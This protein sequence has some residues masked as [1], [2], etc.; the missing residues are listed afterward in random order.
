MSS[1]GA[2][3]KAVLKPGKCDRKVVIGPT[4]HVV[5]PSWRPKAE[6]GVELT[7]VLMHS[8]K[9]GQPVDTTTTF[10]DNTESAL[11]SGA[12]EMAYKIL[13]NK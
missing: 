8:K 12:E 13:K 9:N 1:A 11:S 4:T 5:M 6:R 10:V 2:P 7:T 3:A